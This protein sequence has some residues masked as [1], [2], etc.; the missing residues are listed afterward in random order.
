MISLWSVDD[1]TTVNPPENHQI[2]TAASFWQVSDKKT[3]LIILPA[4]H[5]SGIIRTV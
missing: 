1:I 2:P 5:N 3:K 4:L